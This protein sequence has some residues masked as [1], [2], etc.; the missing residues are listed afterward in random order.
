MKVKYIHKS[1][2]QDTETRFITF[3]LRGQYETMQ[4]SLALG[5]TGS[6]DR[7]T[8]TNLINSFKTLDILQLMF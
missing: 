6:K 7:V 3:E 5:P 1:W 4:L 2:S 8:D